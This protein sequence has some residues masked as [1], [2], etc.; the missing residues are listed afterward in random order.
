MTKPASTLSRCFC[1]LIALLLLSGC[2]ARQNFKAGEELMAEGHYDAAVQKYFAAASKD[3]ETDEYR[4]KLAN[5]SSKAAWQHL[6]AAR[7]LAAKKEFEPAAAE[8]RLALDFDPTL[9]IAHQELKRVEERIRAGLLIDEA[10]EFYRQRRYA[11]AKTDL[12]QALVL[13]AENTQAKAL[14][15]K[16]QAESGTL[17]DGQQLDI[18]STKPITLKFKDAQI[19][20]VFRILSQLSGINFIFDE[21]TKDQ[22]VTVFLED[23][24]FAQ[25]LELL[26]KMNNLGERVLNPKTVIIYSDTKDKEKQYQDQLIQ[27]FYLSNIDAKKAV[28]LLRTMLQLRKIY[29][30]E[31]LN[32]IVIRDTP[33]VIRLAQQI[34][35]AADRA[36]AEVL[37]DLELVEI[38]HSDD[39]NI[40]PRLSTY[41]TSFG[42]VPP[43]TTSIP[44]TVTVEGLSNL[45]FLYTIPTATFQM[46]KTLKDSEILANPKI[47]VKNKEKAKVH[48]GSREPVI[49]VTTTGTTGITSDSIQYVDVGVKLEVEPRV[50]LDNTVDT[51]ISLEVSN[52]T[53][54]NTTDNGTLALTLSTTNASTDLTLKDGET[55]ILGGL[56]RDDYT[57][58]KN[59]F[60][61]LGKI[62]LLGDLISGH[63]RNKNK[64]EILLSITPHIVKSVDVPRANVASIWSGGE[65]DLKAGPNFSAFAQPLQAEQTRLAPPPV[66]GRSTQSAEM[67]VPAQVEP[68]G[69]A[70]ETMP[71]SAAPTTIAPQGLPQ[72]GPPAALP[73]PGAGQQSPAPTP[74]APEA[75]EPAAAPASTGATAMPGM[76]E[77]PPAGAGVAT[78]AMPRR[79]ALA[80]PGQARVFLRGPTLVK[81][82]EEFVVEV[83]VDS[84]HDLYSAPFFLNFPPQL[85]TFTRVEEGG[86]LGS[87]GQPTIFT[88]SANQKNGQLIIGTKQGNAG[89]GASGSG[90]LARIVFTAKAAGSGDL[91]LDR[92]NFRDPSGG[93]LPVAAE[94]LRIEVR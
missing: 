83:D 29:V 59:T 46:E 94:G 7:D 3:P 9:E 57:N 66:P 72:N 63:L 86:F 8:F 20:E 19:K 23:A 85:C 36:D 28:N 40:G 92:I 64:R 45:Q 1:V 22:R 58:T 31:E 44:G 90:T 11:Q 35:E 49:T 75:M 24:T 17:L 76:A 79:E 2:A 60:P 74:P 91:S 26:L 69:P 88:S 43:G 93:R 13:D 33:D 15:K 68:A 47:R 27:I 50:Q 4:V 53:G 89:S 70:P 73:A 41:G 37:Y 77:A 55:T 51:K 38:N 30:H 81:A 6:K 32:A 67:P 14:L 78:V 21:D 61:I 39:M 82:G 52:V 5:A 62:P 54:R 16:I 48:I 34:L 56:I 42:Y 65:D 84:L 25:A 12:Q 87:G 71:E 18:A 80:A 10:E